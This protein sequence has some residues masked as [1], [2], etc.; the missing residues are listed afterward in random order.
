MEN[1]LTYINYALIIKS[2]SA[3]IIGFAIGLEREYRNKPAGIKTF[4]LICLGSTLFTHISLSIQ[5]FSDPSRVTA[6]IVSGLGFIGAGTIFQSRH[7]ITGLTTAAELWVVGALGALLGLEKY[8]EA[9]SCLIII[10][11][12]FILSHF[13]QKIAF[14]KKKYFLEITLE[15][16]EN[17]PMIEELFN[18]NKIYLIQRNWR[19]KG[20]QY[21]FECSYNANP[22]KNQEIRHK[23]RMI[24]YVIGIV[25]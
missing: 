25:N 23:L 19:K 6:Q 20:K 7:M 18:E 21:K 15:D 22:V 11:I 5:G 8:S 17:I 16:K 1:L 4:A 24:E 10:Y 3:C 12:Y 2:I 9:I 13:I 14:K